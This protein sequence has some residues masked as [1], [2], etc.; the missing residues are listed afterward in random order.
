MEPSSINYISLSPVQKEIVSGLFAGTLTILITHPLDLVKLRLQISQEHKVSYSEIIK[1][2]IISPPN[3]T[4]VIREAYRGLTINLLGNGISW[5]LYFGLYR[6][7]KDSLHNVYN[8]PSNSDNHTTFH[9]DKNL[10]ASMYLTAAWLSGLTTSILTNPIWVIKTRIM[11]TNVNGIN[12]YKSILSGCRLIYQNEGWKG[13]TKGLIP[14]LFGV[15]Q[16]AIY[17]SVYDSLKF[18]IFHDSGDLVEKKLHFWQYLFI[19]STSKMISVS[20]AYPFQLLKSNL[21][22]FVDTRAN[23]NDTNN[24]SK[25]LSLIKKIYH[26]NGI[27]GFYKGLGANLLRAIPSTCITFYVY[28]SSKHIL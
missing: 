26:N 12:S 20:I 22:N 2:T 17:F 1:S 10:S 6:Y 3:K 13:F 24:S 4:N 7:F 21:Q 5:G 8:D 11:A 23:N 16:G 27:I 14:A 19:T 9:K 25:L 28:E 15:S 18:R